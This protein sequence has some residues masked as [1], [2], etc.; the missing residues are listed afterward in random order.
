VIEDYKKYKKAYKMN[1]VGG[2]IGQSV[3]ETAE[4]DGSGNPIH[5]YS[6][7]HKYDTRFTK[8]RPPFFPSTN[9]FRVVS[10]YEE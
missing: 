10:W 6:Y 9:F 4:Y 1:L 3:R 8:V 7:V 5:G 2:I